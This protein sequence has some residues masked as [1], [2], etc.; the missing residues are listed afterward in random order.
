ML[1]A[2]QMKESKTMKYPK[3][4]WE[5]HPYMKPICKSR[6]V[7]YIQ[8]YYICPNCGSEIKVFERGTDESTIFFGQC[9]NKKCEWLF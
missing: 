8:N 2:E 6:K 4:D 1:G 9:T 7:E 5:K 3:G